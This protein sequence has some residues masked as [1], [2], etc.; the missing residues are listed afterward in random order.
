MVPDL[1]Q[2]WQYLITA[3]L[4]SVQIENDQMIIGWKICLLARLDHA[5]DEL[6]IGRQIDRL[7]SDDFIIERH[8]EVYHCLLL[9]LWTC[10]SWVY[11]IQILNFDLETVI[12]YQNRPFW[13]Q[14]LY[15]S[16]GV[17]E[18]LAVHFGVVDLSI[19]YC[20]LIFHL[21][22]QVLFL[23]ALI[24]VTGLTVWKPRWN[25]DLWLSLC[26]WKGKRR[27]RWALIEVNGLISRRPPALLL[28]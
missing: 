11:L 24:M 5:H 28:G 16:M 15:L 13:V 6:T 14:Y 3:K 17:G 10:R 8:L 1:I 9:V 26:Q 22:L 25:E 4:A 20:F 23:D 19:L 21:L 27:L 18:D 12:S 2:P 7:N